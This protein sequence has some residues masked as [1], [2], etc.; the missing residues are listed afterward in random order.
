MC[1][2]FFVF[3]FLVFPK[4]ISVSL[5]GTVLGR[6]RKKETYGGYKYLY[7]TFEVTLFEYFITIQ[8]KV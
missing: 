3:C 7:L 1:F 4:M 2:L 8:M 5:L 6:K